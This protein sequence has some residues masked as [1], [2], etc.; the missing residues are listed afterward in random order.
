MRRSVT[1]AFMGLAIAMLG[2]CRKNDAQ[3]QVGAAQAA[4]DSVALAAAQFDTTV[5]DTIKWEGPEGSEA[6]FDRGHTVYRTSCEKCHGPQ[7]GGNGQV[8]IDLGLTVPSFL[9]PGW[10]LA[11]DIPGIR[12]ATYVGH[13][14]PMPSWGLLGLKYRDVDA[15]AYF[16]SR[17][18]IPAQTTEQ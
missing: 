12:R 4:A 5:F 18:M 6:R 2:A 13:T 3:Q 14:G 15:V 16:M 9:V 17:V 8:A 11:G 10:A 7:G 1:L